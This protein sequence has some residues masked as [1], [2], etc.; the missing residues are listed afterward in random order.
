MDTIYSL[1]RSQHNILNPK[2]IIRV[3][4]PATTAI[5]IRFFGG[6]QS[7]IFGTN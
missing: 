3:E 5:K 6:L 4:I 7:E 1:H 2:D